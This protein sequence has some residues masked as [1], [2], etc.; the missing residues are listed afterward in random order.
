MPGFDRRIDAAS[1]ASYATFGYVP[2]PGS[3]FAGV[4]KLPPAHYLVYADGRTSLHRYWSLDPTVKTTLN[5]RD[6]EDALAE[7]LDAAV[8]S[9]LVSDVPFGAFLSGGLDS[10]VVV[11][12][13]SRHLSMPVQTFS[14]GFK[15][16]AFNELSDARRVANHLGTD[17]HELVVEPDAVALLEQLVWYLDE[18]FADASAVPTFLVAQLARTHVKMALTGDGGDEAFAGYDRYLRY[19]KLQQLGAARKPASLAAAAIG[20]LLPGELG[21]RVRRVGRRLAESFPQSYLSGVALSSPE[22]VRELL[23][24]AAPGEAYAGLALDREALG[25]LGD[26]DRI[27]AIDFASYLPDDILVKLDRMAMANSLEG[28]SPLLDHRLVEFAVSLPASLRVHGGR[29]KHLLR[30]V[31][32]RW[33]P[34]DVLA[35]PKQGFGIPLAEWFR[36]PLRELASDTIES[37]PFRERGFFDVAVARRCLSTH[38]ARQADM[39]ETLWLLMSFEL[40][41]RRFID[42][43]ATVPT[44]AAALTA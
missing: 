28:R 22:L 24:R 10:S 44:I 31:A 20:P 8:S 14:I 2:G 15:E 41:C 42:G 4:R 25:R 43:A 9:R 37:R 16:A 33:L 1:V 17:H 40:W 13:M 38:L 36:G 27:V 29:G 32:A 18:P 34:A 12:L 35:K 39:S 3:I 5:E 11:A 30:K 23:P 19:L 7:K 21:H 26:L 6:A